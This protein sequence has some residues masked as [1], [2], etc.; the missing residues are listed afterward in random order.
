VKCPNGHIYAEGDGEP[1]NHHCHVCR[2]NRNA[3]RRAAWRKASAIARAAA[4]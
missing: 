4:A 2:D 3:R 1:G